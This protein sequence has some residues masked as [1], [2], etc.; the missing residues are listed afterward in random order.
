MDKA[1]LQILD[2][3]PEHTAFE[4]VKHPGGDFDVAIMGKG[5]GIHL[6]VRNTHHR[7]EGIGEWFSRALKDIVGKHKQDR[8][9]MAAIQIYNKELND[10]RYP[11]KDAE[12]FGGLPDAVQ[13]H[14][15]SK[16]QQ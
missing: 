9:V 11:I 12:A 16:A 10:I 4:I 5:D 6:P 8:H 13:S 2:A 14:Y 7:K 1:I 15:I 3:M